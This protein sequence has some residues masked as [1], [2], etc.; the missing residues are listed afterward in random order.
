VH[1]FA[2][3]FGEEGSGPGQL[4]EPSGVAVNEVALGAVGDVYVAD[5]GNHRVLRFSQEGTE[6]K[7]AFDGSATPAGSFGELGAIAVDNSENVLDPSRGDVYV[8][9]VGNSVVDKFSSEGTYLSQ[10]AAG[11]A[12]AP[13]GRIFGVAVDPA[14]T[15]WVYQKSKEIDSYSD[16]AT[17]VFL[18]SAESPF[19]TSPGLAVDSKDD[20]Y[21]N[22]GATRFAKL[23]ST[24]GELI[25]AVNPEEDATAA[26]VGVGDNVFIDEGVEPSPHGETISE[27]N[28]E[29]GLI[30]R[31][32]TEHLAGSNGIAVDL[33]HA[34]V[35]ATNSK[36]G[37][38]SVFL[39]VALPVPV[40]GEA[41]GLAVEGAATLNG[42]IDPE[43]VEVTGCRF[44]YGINREYGRSV[45]CSALPGSGSGPVAVSANLS[46]LELGRYHYR[47]VASNNSGE[48]VGADHVF[49]AVGT[50]RISNQTIES[51][52]VT[53][54]AFTAHL[55]LGGAPTTYQVQYGRTA[56]YGS[57]TPVQTAGAGFATGVQIVLRDLSAAAEYHA[58]ITATNEHGTVS[59]PDVTFTTRSANAS[60]ASSACPNKTY[61]GFSSALPD[62]RAYEAVS[63]AAGL[64]EVYAPFTTPAESWPVDTVLTE[65][66]M[67]A[68]AQGD[69]VAYVGE[70]GEEGGTGA[71]A[72]G[73]GNE[74]IAVRNAALRRWNVTAISA[75]P[76]DPLERGAATQA[77]QGF[78]PDLSVG[79][80]ATALRSF[81]ANPLGPPG[82]FA[83]YSRT[84]DS[85]FHGLFTETGT[86]GACGLAGRP[87]EVTES[88]GLRFAGAN[89]GT[90]TILPYSHLLFQSPAP[91]IAGAEP[92]GAEN[93]GLNLYESFDGTVRLVSVLPND[94]PDANAVFGGATPH[95]ELSK[96][97]PDFENA[98]SAD[99]SR[100]FWTDLT[101]GH[102]YMRLDGMST[103]PI[104]QGAATYW[105]ATP[106]GHRVIYT[107][108]EKLWAYDTEAAHGDERQEIA[109]AGAGVQGV[110]GVSADGAYVYFVASGVLPGTAGAES[111]RCRKPEEEYEEASEEEKLRLEAE[112]RAEDHGHLPAARGCN[113]YLS[114]DGTTT[115]ITALG[116]ADDQLAHY[117]GVNVP[118]GPWQGELGSRTAQVADGGQELVFESAQQLTG[119]ENSSL[120]D[121]GP[122]RGLEAFVY[123]A[124]S[125]RLIC[126]SC[127]PA[128]AAPEAG[129]VNEGAAGT[130]LPISESPVY[131]HRWVSED[132]S[133][134]FFDTAQALVPQDSNGTQ[135]VYEWEREKSPGCPI[136]TS[137]W[138][139][140]ISLLSGGEGSDPSYFV[141][142]SADGGDV[143]LLHRGQLH[144]QGR[145]ADKM[146]LFDAR[147][148][149]GF[150]ESTTACTG[151]GC[152]GVPPS[153]PS[154]AAPPSATFAGAG[155]F[156]PHR[157][158]GSPNLTTRKLK[159]HQALKRCMRMKPKRMRVACERRARKR[160][161]PINAKGKSPKR[162]GRGTK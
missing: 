101:S 117:V 14:G 154:F 130:Y 9:D 110:A 133:R 104:S 22:K 85:T 162:L 44:E 64:G 150:P 5:S 26:A 25:E 93:E 7:G 30:E 3:T 105:G 113:L 17:N 37:T 86:P 81:G 124:T 102:V 152:Q 125:H 45:E 146:E 24:G 89:G 48:A 94:E 55:N 58:R 122:G 71:S 91:L 33:A 32:G 137:I 132:G 82:C 99:G 119:Y 60:T 159:L 92:S 62:C 142:A 131:M 68:A 21:V 138:G 39:E 160:Y 49:E 73:L 67:R 147:V 12:A 116:A 19:G 121:R 126:A 66:A 79:I 96:S 109:G 156:A 118:S 38:V 2:S 108:G 43:A 107:E 127:D 88:R 103:V 69:A 51:L 87:G 56:A 151:T 23:T 135:D 140:C 106:D 112:Q 157:P 41:S 78:S 40:T 6:L 141:D 31:F 65:R 84:T 129:E 83:L 128:G 1:V 53:T 120:D 28:P 18:T 70:A 8:A 36:N 143:F 80:L 34:I 13:L 74:F 52:G 139:G 16:A 149:G 50:P 61:S 136:A 97:L 11:A 95:T 98:I 57:S 148:A 46:A 42:T 100:I 54:A 63:I 29:A 155:N 115:F 144:A 123:S 158:S 47:L 27:F 15:V 75:Q 114:H 77:Y 161:G 59:G 20:L 134:V 111:R 72:K 4:K 35:Y 90:A 145:P 76:T 153:A 10:I